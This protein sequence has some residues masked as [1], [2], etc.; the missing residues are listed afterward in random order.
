M[1]SDRE[2]D[3][4][5][6]VQK[7]VDSNKTLLR[8]LIDSRTHESRISKLTKA[9]ESM[10][11]KLTEYDDDFAG[12]AGTISDT[13]ADT[14]RTGEYVKALDG[15]IAG[16]TEL[17]ESAFDKV[18]DL[19]QAGKLEEA[20]ALAKGTSANISEDDF[21]AAV[22]KRVTEVLASKFSID[23]KEA[24]ATPKNDEFDM[25]AWRK[26]PPAER[27]AQH[28]ALVKSMRG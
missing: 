17:S 15:V 27:L 4:Q 22:D 28:D 1:A 6:E 14:V 18:V 11:T 20:A 9:V 24:V 16:D 13:D 5:R 23:T 19:M 2:K 10:A 8:A 7:R 21:E 3:L 25:A 26:L 12:L